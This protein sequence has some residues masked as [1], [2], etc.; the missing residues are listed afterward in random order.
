MV[1]PL[2]IRET[3]LGVDVPVRHGHHVVAVIVACVLLLHPDLAVPVRIDRG[4]R[5]DRGM[6]CVVE[7]GAMREAQDIPLLRRVVNR[8]V[9][10]LHEQTRVGP[11]V[12]VDHLCTVRRLRGCSVLVVQITLRELNALVAGGA[13]RSRIGRDPG[14]RAPVHRPRAARRHNHRGVRITCAKGVRA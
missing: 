3:E 14:C 6:A 12:G 4:G 8:R 9:R 13:D 11:R 7:R 2:H 5:H 10:E 1:Q